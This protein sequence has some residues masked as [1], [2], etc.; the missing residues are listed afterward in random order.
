M[1]GLYYLRSYLL[2]HTRSLLFGV[3]L[4]LISNALSLVLPFILRLAID[5]VHGSGLTSTVRNYAFLLVGVAV[6]TGFFQF[7]ARYVISAVSRDIEYEIRNNL[8]RQ[9]QRLEV[10]YFQQRR[11]GDL[12]ARAT[13]DL[14]AVRMFLGPGINNL[15]N[16]TAAVAATLIVMSQIDLQL[17][18]YTAIIL[19]M[20]T[21]LFLTL[22]G[23][24][25]KRFQKVQDQF[26]ELSA[27]AQENFSGIRVVK[28]YAQENAELIA[29]NETNRDYMTKSI[30]YA[31]YNSLLWPAMFFIA[32]LASAILLWRGG[33][34]VIA[35]RISV[36]QLVQF[37][38]YLVQLTWPMIALGWFVNLMQQGQASLN[39]LREVFEYEPTIKDGSQTDSNATIPSGA[40]TLEHVS[41][42]YEDAEVLHDI[43]FTVPAGTSFAIVGATGSGKSTLVNL[44]TRTFET[45][46]GRILI[47]GNDVRTIPL[48]ELHRA[49]GYVPQESFLFSVP[50]AENVAFGMPDATEEELQHAVETAQLS[51]DLADFPQGMHTMIGER[52]VTLSGGQKQRT[53]IARAVAKN[54]TILI[55]DDALSSV[56]TYTEAEI[57]RRLKVFMKG[58]T[59]IVIAH[60]ISTVK[61]LDNIIVLS[62]GRIVESGTHAELLQRNGIYQGMYRRQLIGEE[63]SLDN[64]DDVPVYDS[65]F[66]NQLAE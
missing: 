3:V 55:M 31:R 26:G 51:K 42:H 25:Q 9:F 14:T 37:N 40:V 8:F 35:G 2:R 52:G 23:R 20:I 11:L 62:E 27:K 38:I 21:I 64:L 17:M 65:S 19:P 58:R 36:G 4:I 32:G 5:E 1:S 46:Q 33:L 43:S 10:G 60:R 44:I 6:V 57:L 12:V 29:F 41:M 50:I 22:N 39:R 30:S 18:Y 28:A 49:I 16:T 13:N 45:D 47:D 56:D 66:S 54:P 48:E 63:L 59:S 24:M 34:D 53:G 15:L 61:D 7:G